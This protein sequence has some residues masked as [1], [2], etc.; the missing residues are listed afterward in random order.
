MATVRVLKIA[1]G[2]DSLFLDQTIFP[3][4]KINFESN[5]NCIFLVF[6]NFLMNANKNET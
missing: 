4:Q 6:L 3:L 5:R 1:R 2:P